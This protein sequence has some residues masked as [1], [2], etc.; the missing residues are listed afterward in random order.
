MTAYA[1]S[2][3][4][5]PFCAKSGGERSKLEFCSGSF[6]DTDHPSTVRPILMDLDE[7]GEFMDKH[8]ETANERLAKIRASYP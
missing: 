4:F 5:C 3:F 7:N 2:A 1:R 6:T 8:G